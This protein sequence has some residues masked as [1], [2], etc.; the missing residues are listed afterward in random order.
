MTLGSLQHLAVEDEV[1]ILEG[2]WAP[3]GD[4]KDQGWERGGKDRP[5]QPG[6]GRARIPPP[7]QGGL[8]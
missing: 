7:G 4:S 1:S 6:Q 3:H 5:R 2:I 8:G